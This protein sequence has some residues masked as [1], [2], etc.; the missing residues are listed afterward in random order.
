MKTGPLTEE[1]TNRGRML[2]A[3]SVFEQAL[4]A[5]PDE[6]DRLEVD[7]EYSDGI[8]IKVE[9]RDNRK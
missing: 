7:A 1:P 8:R 6:I 4:R 2:R 3:L 5:Q 9:V